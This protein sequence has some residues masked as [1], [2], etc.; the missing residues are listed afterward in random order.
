MT[1]LDEGGIASPVQQ[2]DALLSP[3][4]PQIDRS[5][6]RCREGEASGDASAADTAAA[7]ETAV[8]LGT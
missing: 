6:E 7:L 4:E 2:Q 5:T 8:A 1:A 3:L